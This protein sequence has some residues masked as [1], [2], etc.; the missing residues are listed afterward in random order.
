MRLAISCA[1]SPEYCQ[2]TLTT[3]ISILGKMSVAVLMTTIGAR[4]NNIKDKTTNVYGR[5]RA[6]RTIHILLLYLPRVNRLSRSS[7]CSR[8]VIPGQDRVHWH[9]N[10]R[11]FS[12][13]KMF[14][15][16]SNPF[17]G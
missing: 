3:G 16:C 8:T 13:P 5:W 14:Q 12:F 17:C 11:T 9:F 15:A 2:M 10:Y 1:D 6:S 4:S 7:E